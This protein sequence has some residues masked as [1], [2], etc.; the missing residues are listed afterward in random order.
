MA[1][2]YSV[3]CQDGTVQVMWDQCPEYGTWGEF[4]IGLYQNT[5]GNV[6][7]GTYTGDDG[8]QPEPEPEDDGT[9]E[10]TTGDGKKYT[11]YGVATGVTVA[12]G[13]LM[14]A[15]VLLAASAGND[16]IGPDWISRPVYDRSGYLHDDI[17]FD[18]T[19][20]EGPLLAGMG[21]Q[22]AGAVVVLVGAAIYVGCFVA[23]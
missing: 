14:A 15:G 10:V 17:Y 18:P 23:T 9:V 3:Q 19:P 22:V 5:M 21:L 20:E 11:C 2:I 7:S 12:G 8:Y 6:H 16:N 13:A 4:A 1:N